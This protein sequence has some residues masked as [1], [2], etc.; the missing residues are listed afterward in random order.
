MEFFHRKTSYPFMGT[1]RRWCVVSAILIIAALTSLFVRGLNLGIDFTGGVVLELEFPQ[2]VDLEKVRV[3]VEKAGFSHAAVQSFGTSR[4]V[5]VRLLPQQGEDTNKVAQTVLAAIQADV[6][7]A[8]L[9]RTEV[10]GSVVGEE[11]AQKG[12]LAMLFTFVGILIYV[13]LRFQW[14]LGIGAIVAALH[15]PVIILGFF[16][17][18]QMTFDLP[19]LAAILA[20]IGYSLND[21][22]VVFDRIRERFLSH[23][24]G[25]PAQ[26]IDAAINETLS[27]T[28]MTHLTTMITIVAL[29]VFGGE[30]LR[31]FSVALAIG[32]VVGTYSSIYIASAIALDLNLTAR[33][34]LPVQ[35]EKGAVDD[36]P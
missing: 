29:L 7:D 21:T 35:K 20:I 22:V 4:E 8:E 24:K 16:S 19:A 3:S 14:K 25:T 2:A 9:R 32:V 5:M 11:L 18:T 31:G 6:P 36:M 12:A 17:E 30:V 23:R 28:I 13:A 1:R 15:D 10:V 33:D 27:R 26:V 34:L